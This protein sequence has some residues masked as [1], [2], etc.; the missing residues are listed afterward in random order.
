MESVKERLA[1]TRH[2]QTLFDNSISPK[3]SVGKLNNTQVVT[4]DSQNSSRKSAI[5]KSLSKF[6]GPVFSDVLSSALDMAGKIGE[7]LRIIGKELILEITNPY[8]PEWRKNEKY[9]LI[10]NQFSDGVDQYIDPEHKEMLDLWK[11]V[12]SQTT[13]EDTPSPI[14]S[15]SAE[16]EGHLRKALCCLNNS[17]LKFT[18]KREQYQAFMNHFEAALESDYYRNAVNEGNGGLT[19]EEMMS[20]E[21]RDF[22]I[23]LIHSLALVEFKGIN[24]QGFT[25]GVSRGIAEKGGF[26]EKWEGG[27]E[28]PVAALQEATKLLDSASNGIKLADSQVK[29]HTRTLLASSL[30]GEHS[31]FDFDPL[32]T[33]GNPANVKASLSSSEGKERVMV[34]TPSPTKG[35][36][37]TPMFKAYLRALKAREQKHVYVNLQDRRKPNEK[38]MKGKIGG[39][40]GFTREDKRVDALEALN[41]DPEF[42][43][44]ISVFSFD[45]NSEWYWQSMDKEEIK[46]SIDELLDLGH[47]DSVEAKQMSRKL[48]SHGEWADALEDIVERYKEN[49]LD[50][51]ECY[52]QNT[53]SFIQDLMIQYRNEKGGYGF[54]DEWLQRHEDNLEAIAT[55]VGNSLFEGKESLTPK[56][57][58]DY[59]EIV[60]NYTFLYILAVED[61]DAFNASCKDC[62]DRGG[63]ATWLIIASLVLLEAE[64]CDNPVRK[65]E[66]VQTARSLVA[67]FN[68]DA[69]WARKRHA[70][71]ERR[72]RARNAFSHLLDNREGLQNFVQGLKSAGLFQDLSVNT[73]VN[74][75]EMQRA[76]SLI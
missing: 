35:T 41:N 20:L 65:T 46:G 47:I 22:S 42:S 73:S 8:D 38:E 12:A 69:V 19:S 18:S 63:G 31:A 28:D 2:L 71:D 7:N 43:G 51:P 55:Q 26:T 44:A 15:G 64:S 10:L 24:T 9:D 40:F 25:Q 72:D 36:V 21:K 75:Q 54:P 50:V 6:I 11:K 48:S 62:I 60:Y 61:P 66:L 4:T 58:Q 39:M 13:L 67:K 17:K 33:G 70:I 59:L 37:V 23:A 76:K 1:A 45:K 5:N 68:E 29:T 56:E 14:G 52:L 34:R 16:T 57:R 3:E 30:V 27:E 74:E 32:I 49:N 53:D